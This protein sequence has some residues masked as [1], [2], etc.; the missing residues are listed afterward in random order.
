MK[1]LF[2]LL[3]FAAALAVGQTIPLVPSTSDVQKLV[4]VKHVQTTDPQLRSLFDTLGVKATGP[5]AG[6]IVLKGPKDAVAAAEEVVQ[7][8]DL[9]KPA[10]DIEVTGWVIIA[11]RSDTGLQ[12]APAALEPVMKQLKAAFG[13]SRLALLTNFVVRAH[14]G[15]RGQT[16][17]AILPAMGVNF[18]DFDFSFLDAAL[19]VDDHERR[20]I[21]LYR[22]SF[23]ISTGGGHNVQFISDVDLAEGQK[24]VIG[25]TSVAPKLPALSVSGNGSMAE[26]GETPLMLVLSAHVASD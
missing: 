16:N 18:G 5:L 3:I 10:P 4:P 20:Q 1:Q 15:A 21:H 2:V 19:A 23:A 13:Y 26:A 12:P 9:Q 11:S 17:G 6:Y 8:M 24:V 7:K 14:A 25:K 22:M